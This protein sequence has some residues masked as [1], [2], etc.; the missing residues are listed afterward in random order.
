MNRG[1]VHA[2]TSEQFIGA[3]AQL[4]SRTVL[5]FASAIDPD[6]GMVCEIF[7]FKPTDGRTDGATGTRDA[8]P[9]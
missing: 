7:K 8:E 6:Q 2:D 9:S 4:V 1:A 5:A 3:V